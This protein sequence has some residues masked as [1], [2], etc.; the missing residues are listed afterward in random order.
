MVPAV[1]SGVPL[2]AD[3]SAVEVVPLSAP[4]NP[5]EQESSQEVE[6]RNTAV[7]TAAGGGPSVANV[8]SVP[9]QD[10]LDIPLSKLH[11]LPRNPHVG[12]GDPPSDEEEA[13]AAKTSTEAAVVVGQKAA[14]PRF[15]SFLAV[16]TEGSEVLPTVVGF[17][18]G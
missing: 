6:A 5:V 8:S 18:Q 14:S 4:A 2:P 10:E 3:L 1:V 15:S 17:G 9:R 16:T 13:S 12:E 7:K 11:S